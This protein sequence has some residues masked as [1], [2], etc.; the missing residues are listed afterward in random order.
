M[1]KWWAENYGDYIH[2]SDHAPMSEN[3]EILIEESYSE[4]C[5]EVIRLSREI[6]ALEN[7]SCYYSHWGCSLLAKELYI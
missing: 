6:L 7:E 1:I 5:Q 2:P 3:K 4:A